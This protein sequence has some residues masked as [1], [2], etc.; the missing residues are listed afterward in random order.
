MR[1][2]YDLTVTANT[3]EGAPVSSDVLLVK[4]RLIRVQIRFLR[5]CH[6]MV[7]VVMRDGLTRIIPVADSVALVGDGKTFD[8]PM[9]YRLNERAP[10]VVLEG[11]SPD[12]DYDHTI[13]WYIDL[14]PDGDDERSA[15]QALLFDA[16]NIEGMI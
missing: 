7:N 3:L 8:V 4:G 14:T 12:T 11:W 6:N 5:G 2:V 9:S 13:T 10:Q 16:P 1:F 15:L